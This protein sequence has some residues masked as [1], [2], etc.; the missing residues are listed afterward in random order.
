MSVPRLQD[1]ISLAL[2]LRI[3]ADVDAILREYALGH[4]ETIEQLYDG[5]K[6]ALCHF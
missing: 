2:A 3:V 1:T 4:I 6:Y 5:I